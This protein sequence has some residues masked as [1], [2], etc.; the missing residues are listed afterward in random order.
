MLCFVCLCR[1]RLQFANLPHNQDIVKCFWSTRPMVRSHLL[2]YYLHHKLTMACLFSKWIIIF[3]LSCFFRVHRCHQ[4]RWKMDSII[5]LQHHRLQQIDQLYQQQQR[6][7]WQLLLLHRLQIFLLNPS[8]MGSVEMLR[9]YP[10]RW[11]RC[12]E[13]HSWL[14]WQ[15]CRIIQ[16][17]IPPLHRLAEIVCLFNFI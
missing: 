8:I 9:I 3:R 5:L 17:F 10:H 12:N 11:H 16:S 6:Q 7:Q 1:F 2:W 14:H 15:R 13:R 4:H